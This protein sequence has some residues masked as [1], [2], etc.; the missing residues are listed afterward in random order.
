VVSSILGQVEMVINLAVNVARQGQA[1]TQLALRY[2]Q[3]NGQ[4]IEDLA[5][6]I[7]QTATEMDHLE[8]L[9]FQTQI[10]TKEVI[11]ATDRQQID[12][13]QVGSSIHQ[14]GDLIEQN[15]QSGKQAAEAIYHLKKLSQTLLE[16]L[17]QS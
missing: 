11:S 3:E 2:A 6:A 12:F 15:A 4:I 13:G 17:T 8:H 5:T 9:A 10:L 1:Q 14:V 16:T 7:G